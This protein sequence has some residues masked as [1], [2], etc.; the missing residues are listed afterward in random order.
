LTEDNSILIEKKNQTELSA[1]IIEMSN[2]YTTYYPAELIDNINLKFG[3]TTIKKALTTF[4]LSAID[5]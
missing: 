3:A 1:A 5:D 4:Y 2:T